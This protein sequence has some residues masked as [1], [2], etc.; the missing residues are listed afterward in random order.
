MKYANIYTPILLFLSAFAFFFFAYPNHL[1]FQEQLQLFQFTSDYW[2]SSVSLPGGLANYIGRFLTQFYLYPLWG[3][4]ILA[5]LLC[6]TYKIT[7]VILH[8]LGVVGLCSALSLIPSFICWVLLCNENYMLSGLIAVVVSLC[9]SLL[10]QLAAAKVGRNVSFV[11]AVVLMPILYWSFGGAVILFVA[12][13]A[14]T[15]RMSK[16]DKF[17]AFVSVLLLLF[18]VM[19]LAFRSVFDVQYPFLRTYIGAD[20]FRYIPIV[21]LAV[22]LLFV[23][24]VA[25]FL[26]ASLLSHFNA[27]TPLVLINAVVLLGGFCSVFYVADFGR[28]RFMAYDY[29]T[30]MRKWS[31]VI[32][33]ADE[34]SPRDPLSVSCLN[35]AL[36]MQNRMSDDMFKYYQNGVN[37]LIPDFKIDEIVPM[38]TSEIYY[39]LGFINTS[40]RFAF[41]AMESLPDFQKSVR[42]VKRL[43]E[44]SAIKGNYVLARKYLSMLCNTLFY[45]KW[46]LANMAVIDQNMVSKHIEWGDLRNYMLQKDFYFSEGEKDMML[47]LLYMENNNNRMAFEYLMAYSMLRGEIDN[48]MKYFP[49]GQHFYSYYPKYYDELRVFYLSNRQPEALRSQMN[50]PNVRRLENFRKIY[51]QNRSDKRLTEQFGDT[52]WHYLLCR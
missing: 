7:F 45:R 23:V 44:T 38:V 26:F 11:I 15:W 17:W 33:L 3:A 9:V 29:N 8:R 50:N 6:A 34:K 49:L 52:Y 4:A 37:G 12:C 36:A 48:C 1:H 10:W 20:Y 27:K 24:L 35:L 46:A 41:E 16:I 42:A 39:H 28:E 47:G 5:T 43:A 40:E 2:L 31:K 51:S 18:I 25:E 32:D 19:P 30:R 21:P 13:C 22:Y 14:A